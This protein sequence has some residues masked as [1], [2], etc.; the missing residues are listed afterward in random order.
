[1]VILRHYF[2]IKRFMKAES[3][4]CRLLNF[5]IGVIVLEVTEYRL[6]YRLCIHNLHM[7][8]TLLSLYLP[9]LFSFSL[10][11]IQVEKGRLYLIYFYLSSYKPWSVLLRA[12]RAV[13]MGACGHKCM[14]G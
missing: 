1:M 14:V 12:T 10:M 2:L 8:L 7:E 5:K 13:F 6:I 4:I 11:S 9:S 3:L